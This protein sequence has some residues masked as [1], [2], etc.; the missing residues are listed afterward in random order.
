M[1]GLKKQ[2]PP[3][4]KAKATVKEVKTCNEFGL[5]R[6]F[7]VLRKPQYIGVRSELLRVMRSYQ[8]PQSGIIQSCF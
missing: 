5:T 3:S 4:V 2:H 8:L 7:R 1:D 6:G